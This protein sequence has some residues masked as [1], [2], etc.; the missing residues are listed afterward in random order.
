[1]PIGG[2]LPPSRLVVLEGEVLIA[3]GDVFFYLQHCCPDERGHL[4]PALLILS[5]LII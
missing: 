3:V 4:V 2:H 5:C 1:M